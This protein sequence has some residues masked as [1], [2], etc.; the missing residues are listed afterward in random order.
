MG[1]RVRIS[2]LR[3]RVCLTGDGGYAN[4]DPA[5]WRVHLASP[6]ISAVG[7]EPARLKM[8]FAEGVWDSRAKGKFAVGIRLRS[9]PKRSLPDSCR[10]RP[11]HSREQGGEAS[12]VRASPLLSKAFI[13]PTFTRPLL[14]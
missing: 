11:P 9:C 12:S 4:A 10:L 8:Q 7:I 2:F 13:I 1:P 3:R 6:R 5:P 14:P